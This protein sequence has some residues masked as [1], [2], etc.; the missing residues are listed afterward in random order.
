MA[1]DIGE[2]L[3]SGLYCTSEEKKHCSAF[4]IHSLV[5]KHSFLLFRIIFHIFPPVLVITVLSEICL[6][7]HNLWLFRTFFSLTYFLLILKDL[8][9]LSHFVPMCNFTFFSQ[10]FKQINPWM[11]SQGDFQCSFNVLFRLITWVLIFSELSNEIRLEGLVIDNNPTLTIRD[12]SLS[13]IPLFVKWPLPV[14]CKYQSCFQYCFQCW[15]VRWSRRTTVSV[16]WRRS[17]SSQLPISPPVLSPKSVSY[18]SKKMWPYHVTVQ[19]C[20][21]NSSDVLPSL[22]TIGLF[23]VCL[24]LK[25]LNDIAIISARLKELISTRRCVS[26]ASPNRTLIIFVATNDYGLPSEWEITFSMASSRRNWPTWSIR[27]NVLKP[28]WW[29]RRSFVGLRI[30]IMLEGFVSCPR[31]IEE[32][33]HRLLSLRRIVIVTISRINVLLLVS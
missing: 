24:T 19:T 7:R 5:H 10:N 22:S 20:V 25:T 12:S 16:V 28:A 21:N 30:L 8:Q 14:H 31:R 17:R 11:T 13:L 2:S 32:L 23:G 15:H 26:R 4:N 33:N 6:V 18:S 29:K 9:H 1:A 3:H 27:R